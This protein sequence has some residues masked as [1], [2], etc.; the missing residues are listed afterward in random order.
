MFPATA[1]GADALGERLHY[2]LPMMS[3]FGAPIYL[4]ES[5][6]MLRYSQKHKVGRLDEHLLAEALCAPMA[7]SMPFFGV[8]AKPLSAPARDGVV[9]T[10]A[11]FR[12]EVCQP[13]LRRGFLLPSGPVLP[14]SKVG[15]SPLSSI[16]FVLG[17]PPMLSF[18]EVGESSRGGGFKEIGGPPEAVIDLSFFFQTLGVSHEGNVKDFLDF[19][20]QVDVEQCQEAP[21]STSK[22]KGS[23][24]VKNLECR[25]NYDA[26][27]FGFSWGKARGLLM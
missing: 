26:R 20:A 23:C 2:S 12:D 4:L 18:S 3:K 11:P 17:C 15:G 1:P 14:P 13:L 27:D 8:A 21:V 7:P 19:M 9:S 5:K 24:E 10:T 25:I 22:F 6:S 16:Q